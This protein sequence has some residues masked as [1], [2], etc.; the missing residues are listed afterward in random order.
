[1]EGITANVEVARQNVMNSIGIVT[2]LNP[3]IGH[4]NG[5]RVGRECARSGRGVREVVLEMG[6]LSAEELDDILSPSNLLRP[7]YK[8]KADKRD[9]AQ[10]GQDM[11]GPT[12]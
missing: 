12:A 3:I 9:V 6:L 8:G 10:P 2:Y 4:H 7:K 11:T 1:M 5:D